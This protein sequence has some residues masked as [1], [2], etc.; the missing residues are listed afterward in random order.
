MTFEKYRNNE[1]GFLLLDSLVTLN[2][3]MV[4]ILL[5][6]PLMTDWLVDYSQAKELVEQNRLLYENTMEQ[7]NQPITDQLDQL[8]ERS[9]TPTT[10]QPSK[11]QEKGAGIAVYE[12][13][14]EPETISV[15]DE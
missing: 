7:N 14:F 12:I 15:E 3:I 8:I 10:K 6:T 1:A 4:V 2:I 13:H 11:T 9:V 5:L